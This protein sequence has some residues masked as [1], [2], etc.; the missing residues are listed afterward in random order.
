MIR[1]SAIT[2]DDAMSERYKEQIELR[3][4]DSAADDDG[5][6]EGGSRHLIDADEDDWRDEQYGRICDPRRLAAEGNLTLHDE[7]SRMLDAMIAEVGPL[8][9]AHLRFAKAAGDSELA[10]AHIRNAVSLTGN[11]AKLVDRREARLKGLGRHRG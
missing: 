8:A 3:H 4:E 6:H 9:M 7:A 5:E 1:P 2:G 11:Y 10:G